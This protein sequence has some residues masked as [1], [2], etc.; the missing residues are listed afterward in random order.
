MSMRIG[1]D[2]LSSFD[3]IITTSTSDDENE[4]VRIKE[5]ALLFI[6]IGTANHLLRQFRACDELIRDGH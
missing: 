1:L 6:A 3:L 2:V 5:I 4:R